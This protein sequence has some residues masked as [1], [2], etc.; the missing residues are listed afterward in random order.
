MIFLDLLLSYLFLPLRTNSFTE[1]DDHQAI[2]LSGLREVTFSYFVL[3]PVSPGTPDVIGEPLPFS[4]IDARGT[5][6]TLP[7]YQTHRPNLS[8]P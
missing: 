7:T 3:R 5:W 1:I 8:H 6:C 4:A 2:L